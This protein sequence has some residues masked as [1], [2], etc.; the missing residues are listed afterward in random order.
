MQKLILSLI[1]TFVFLFSN[2]LA[3][4]N[5]VQITGGRFFIKSGQNQDNSNARIET[6]NFTASGI[7]GG[8]NS[9]WFGI[10]D[11][12][13]R[14]R[15][16]MTFSVIPF[17]RLY[18]GGCVGDCSQ[19]TGGTFTL[20]GTTYQIAYYEGYFDFSR[21]EFQVPRVARRKGL[22]TL[23]KPFSLAG[24]LKVCQV[25]MSLAACPADKILFDGDIKGEGILTVTG[26]IKVLDTG[27]IIYP[28]LYPS[29]YEYQF[30]P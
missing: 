24:H 29:N 25:S 9:P 12:P 14:C 15:A 3:Q 1:F 5:P 2:A 28:Y 23:R 18:I 13:Q 19:F 20:N 8:F 22:I 10:C 16:G 21:V 6:A 17:S 7:L 26:Q 11:S 30:A 27:T 4:T